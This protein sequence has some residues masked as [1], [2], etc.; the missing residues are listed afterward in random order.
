LLF[1]PH[2]NPLLSRGEGIIKDKT[3]TNQYKLNFVM[4]KNNKQK[5]NLII[6]T[7]AY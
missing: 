2:P 1:T 7:L 3:F 5:S 4:A 6:S